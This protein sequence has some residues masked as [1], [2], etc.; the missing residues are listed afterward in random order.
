MEF[1][2]LIHFGDIWIH[3]YSHP[4]GDEATR[5]Q[6][7]WDCFSD[8][9]SPISPQGTNI[10]H[11]VVVN[12]HRLYEPVDLTWLPEKERINWEKFFRELMVAYE[13]FCQARSFDLLQ[14]TAPITSRP[15][16]YFRPPLEYNSG[17]NT[18]YFFEQEQPDL[19]LALGIEESYDNFSTKIWLN[20][21]FLGIS[22]HIAHRGLC[23]HSSALVRRNDGF[24]FLG[25]SGAGKTTV[26]QLSASVGRPAL[27]DDLNFIFRK[28]DE[29]FL[30]AIPSPMLSPAGYSMQ[31]PVLRGIF[32]LIQD[33]S[34]HL[35][36]ISSILT[37]EAL[38]DG[39][40]QVPFAQ[41]LPEKLVSLAFETCCD[42]ARRVPGYELHFRKSP[43]FW[44][45]IDEQFPD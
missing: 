30:A 41:K 19:L 43:D 10:W 26:T 33:E 35:V 3:L 6:Q 25:D 11:L 39:F 29:C 20:I 18:G 13:Q 15:F 24:L 44:K 32:T 28:E 45:V 12:L 16:I 4:P 17:S 34:N 36:P 40:M 37:A 14:L 23:L 21:L 42:I 7:Y 38:L 5:F 9:Y 22:W 2:S 8:Q 31:R 1:L 27:G